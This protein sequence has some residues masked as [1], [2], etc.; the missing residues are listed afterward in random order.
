MSS[1]S[2]PEPPAIKNRPSVNARD[3]YRKAQSNDRITANVDGARDPITVLI[4]VPT[5]DGGAADAGALELVRIL[6]Q[7]GHRAIVASSGGRL[8]PG[9]AADGAEM[10]R[11]NM[12]SRNPLVI[13]RNAFVLKHLIAQHRCTLVHALARS[14]RLRRL[15]YGSTSGVYGDCAGERIDETRPLRPARSSCNPAP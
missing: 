6:G 14:K 1:F 10:V 7:A 3:E 13:A 12:A 15:V 5:L 11:L 2:V 8:E 4:V 9:L